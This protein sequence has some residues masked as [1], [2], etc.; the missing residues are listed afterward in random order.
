MEPIKIKSSLGCKFCQYW[1]SECRVF[2]DPLDGKYYV[3]ELSVID[4]EE[5][6]FETVFKEYTDLCPFCGRRLKS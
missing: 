2:I 3:E 6:E 4:E 1:S 5:Q